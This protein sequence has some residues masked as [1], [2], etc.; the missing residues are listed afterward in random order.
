MLPSTLRNIESLLVDL[1]FLRDQ[2]KAIYTECQVSAG[3]FKHVVTMLPLAKNKYKSDDEEV[4]KNCSEEE[5]E[6]KKTLFTSYF[7]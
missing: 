2:W 4:D 1:Q 7:T 3:N 5:I 6:L